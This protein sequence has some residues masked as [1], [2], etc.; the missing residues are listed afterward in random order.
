[1]FITHCLELDVMGAAVLRTGKK[2][3]RCVRKLKPNDR[4]MNVKIFKI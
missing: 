1:M 3:V 4:Q 2:I